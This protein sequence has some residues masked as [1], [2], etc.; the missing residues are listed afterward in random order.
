MSSLAEKFMALFKGNERLHG[1][2]VPQATEV[3]RDDNKLEAKHYSKEEPTTISHWVDHLSGKL[4][5]GIA[6]VLDDS[7]V[8]WGAIDIDKYVDFNH[9]ELSR[10][11][12]GLPVV[13]AKSKSGGAHIYAFTD[14]AVPAALMQKKLTAFA[15]GLGYGGK[16][17]EIFPKQTELLTDRGDHANWMNMPYFGATGRGLSAYA[18]N[19]GEPLGAEEFIGI[20]YAKR[21]GKR[22]L[23]KL[24]Y[25]AIV[26][27]TSQIPD[28]PPCLQH[29]A[30]LGF[31]QGSRNNGLFNVA[32][33]LRKAFP[34]TW[35][36]KL[37]EANRD[38][39]KPPLTAR[40]V[41]G[42]RRSVAAKTYGYKCNE[43]PICDHCDRKLCA[44]RKF[45]ISGGNDQPPDMSGLVRIDTDPPRYFLTVEGKRIGPIEAGDLAA[46]ERFQ[47]ACIVFGSLFPA[48]VKQ[49][50]WRKAVQELLDHQMVVEMPDDSSARGQLMIHVEN[51]CERRSSP[52]RDDLKVNRVWDD[53]ETYHFRMI[54]LMEYLERIRFKDFSSTDI[55]SQFHESKRISKGQ[56]NL[57]NKENVR[58]WKFP[59]PGLAA[60]LPIPEYDPKDTY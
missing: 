8:Y 10:K 60:P 26:A 51:F 16:S 2:R 30:Q 41:E 53:G 38:L 40:E 1:V 59:K 39:M 24:E 20:A 29:L 27:G 36:Q 25:V 34:D 18:Y 57:S 58:V 11:L 9:E 48:R 50:T 44:T 52:S 19:D 56:V 23:D 37:E 32:V 22:E 49:D 33:Y 46:Q 35:E 12:K 55:A 4:G 54:D 45:G 17:S 43:Q 5:L 31:P 21:M 14:E 42:V 28:G 3:R 6:P 13:V 15:A 7:T 47:K